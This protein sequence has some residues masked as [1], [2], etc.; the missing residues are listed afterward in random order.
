[1]RDDAPKSGYGYEYLQ[2]VAVYT[3]W[4][5]EYV[6]GSWDD[7]YQ[8]L[9]DGKIDLMVAVAR[10]EGRSHRLGY[11]DYEMLSENIYIYKDSDDAS[12]KCGEFSSYNGKR[13]GI[14]IADE[15][16]NFWLEHW[17]GETGAQITVV[18][19]ETMEAC[20]EGFNEKKVDAFVSAE[21]IVSSYAGITPVEKIG[22]EPYYLCVTGKH[23]EFLD[24]LNMAL[25]LLLYHHEFP[26]CRGCSV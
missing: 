4:K 23:P 26:G 8:M 15:K 17:I 19:Y 25:S 18:P 22:R 2:R 3:G 5:Y 12:M 21:N 14:N 20:T 7:L 1:M 6:Y 13:V 10:D 11:P 9:L 16:M 24:E